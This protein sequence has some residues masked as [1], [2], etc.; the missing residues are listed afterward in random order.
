MVENETKLVVH[1]QLQK[2]QTSRVA[3]F[4]EY[5]SF[6]FLYPRWAP[7]VVKRNQDRYRESHCHLLRLK[8]VG[9]QVGSVN[10]LWVRVVCCDSVSGPI[11]KMI[12]GFVIIPKS[13]LAGISI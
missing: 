3:G 9:F 10:L 11:S 6:L 5:R 4:F 7:P 12:T 8:R 13:L 2:C 1:I